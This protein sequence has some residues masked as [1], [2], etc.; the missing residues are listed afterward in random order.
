MPAAIRASTEASGSSPACFVMR[1]ANC[2]ACA[3]VNSLFISASACG[4]TVE[5]SPARTTRRRIRRIENLQHR[6]RQRPLH[7]QI[8]AAA[9]VL[10]W[11]PDSRATSCGMRAACISSLVSGGITPTPPIFRFRVP[12]TARMVSRKRIAV[13]PAPVHAAEIVILRILLETLL[14]R[15]ARRLVRVR[16]HDQPVHLLDAPAALGELHRQPIEQFR[17]SR[18]LLPG[19][20]NRWAS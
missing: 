16:Q 5:L 14:V 4:A 8:D 11:D 10:R 12:A 19:G 6:Q 2:S 17:M 9:V 13:Q 20:R 15:N 18:R 3:T 7:L 1:A